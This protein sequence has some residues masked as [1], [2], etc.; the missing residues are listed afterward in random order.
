MTK[1]FFIQVVDTL[2]KLSKVDISTKLAANRTFRMFTKYGVDLYGYQFGKD[3]SNEKIKDGDLFREWLNSD[4]IREQLAADRVGKML[5]K[6][7][8]FPK[9]SDLYKENKAIY[10]K[11]KDQMSK[12]SED[13]ND[14]LHT[15][16]I[17]TQFGDG[18][19]VFV[20]GVKSEEG[21]REIRKWYAWMY[22][23][24][25]FQV[26]ECSF[27]YWL[28][29]PETQDAT[30]NYEYQNDD[31]YKEEIRDID[32][33]Y[34]VEPMY[35][36]RKSTSKRRG[37]VDDRNDRAFKKHRKFDFDEEIDDFEAEDPDSWL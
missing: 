4:E 33:S 19:V 15:Y 26:R 22:K 24:N 6:R 3:L 16:A 31:L 5:I 8:Q 36:K 14:P 1:K 20:E 13:V 21:R 10:D 32:E 7:I 2:N 34:N 12:K 9:K 35:R 37:M 27:E 30:D 18:P 17:R 29:H 28:K 11:Y 25:Y 23:V